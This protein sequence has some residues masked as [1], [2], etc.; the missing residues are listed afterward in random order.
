VGLV[1]E[2]LNLRLFIDGIEVPVIGAK[3]TFSEGTV[4]TAEI[5]VVATDLVY[6]LEPRSFITLFV[7]DNYDY[8]PHPRS[9]EPNG[10]R[11]G[12]QDLRRWKLLFSGELVAV[13]MNKQGAARAATL[14]CADHT[15]YWDFIRQHYINFRNAG[16][17]LFEAAF[18]GVKQ[19]RLKFFDVLTTGAQSRLYVWLT[20]SKNKSGEAS[21]YLGMQRMLR[22]MFFSVNDFYAEMFNRL[23]IGDC[24][25]G[26]QED[27]TAAKLFKLQFFEKFIKNKVGGQGSMVSARQLV[28][29]LL[30]PVMHTYVTVPCPRFDRKGESLGFTPEAGSELSK[31]LISRDN[32]WPGASLNQ[33]I[34]KPDTWFLAPPMC[35]VVFPHQ[36]RSV[37][38]GRNYLAEPTRMFLR[39]SLLFTGADKWLTERF[40]APDFKSFNKQL[41]K[42]GG[43]LQRLA[44]T[45]LPHEKFVGLNPIMLWEEDLPAYVAKG[46]RRD[47]LSQLTHYL[48]WKHRFGTRTV[49]VSGP[50][51]LNLVPG[52]PGLVLDRVA[53][54]DYQLVQG[55]RV[56]LSVTRHFQ[57]NITTVVH[58]VDQVGGWTHF[59]M[60]GARV[61]DERADFD[62]EGRSLEE[63]VARGTDGFLDSRYHAGKIG[64]NVYQ[65]LFGCNSIVDILSSAEKTEEVSKK[66]K[67]PTDAQVKAAQEGVNTFYA[68]QRTTLQGAN[69]L[70]VLSE[71]EF[72]SRNDE[73]LVE[74]GEE[75]KRA[76]SQQT[77]P[78][79]EEQTKGD[80]VPLAVDKLHMLYREALK[81]NVNIDL[82]T[83]SLTNRPKATF[84]E[85]MGTDLANVPP[86]RNQVGDGTANGSLWVIWE[87]DLELA[88]QEGF[89]AS[90]VNPG[91]STTQDAG[92]FSGYR[93]FERTEL[94]WQE[95]EIQ[96]PKTEIQTEIVDVTEEGDVLYESVEVTLEEGIYQSEQVPVQ[97]RYTEPETATYPLQ[98]NLEARR[99]KVRAYV[100]SLL[101]KGLRG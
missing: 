52:Y 20:Q 61:H 29:G 70:G 35:N 90:A 81:N 34:I 95:V 76:S 38:F 71:A 33:T 13:S 99:A 18:L 19:D 80:L 60:A 14:S 9:G 87:Q 62:D 92:Y 32:S 59:S 64:A 26:L 78:K 44:G 48:F 51:N 27:E 88:G 50:L 85:M 10:Q 15:N 43:Y 49:N 65:K 46:P 47:Y 22:E 84:P 30:G 6:D 82:W 7:Y 53:T 45:N 1:A 66:V 2:R 98:Q 83:K 79:I 8:I 3:C 58:S 11:I 17:E 72:Q 75:L 94:E 97:K 86:D 101:H 91:A 74:W 69:V 5:Q 55:E 4:A 23:R 93:T 63:V 41:Y 36:C 24:I 21:L 73:L 37:N 89:F 42:E 67:V 12:G 54:P 16:V 31:G 77:V 39:T 25:V 96:P 68:D 56:D 57:G 28:D 40:Y 100:G